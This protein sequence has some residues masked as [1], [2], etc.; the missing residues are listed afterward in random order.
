MEEKGKKKLNDRR[1]AQLLKQIDKGNVV[2]V[3]GQELLSVEIDGEKIMLKD[4]ILREIANRL[5]LEFKEGMDFAQFSFEAQ[6]TAWS[7]IDSDPYYETDK[8]ISELKA[9]DVAIPEPLYKLLSID[10]F[11]KVIT[12]T[13]NDFVYEAMKKQRSGPVKQLEYKKNSTEEDIS[14]NEKDFVYHM[15][16]KVSPIRDYV[17]TDDDMLEFMHC[18]MDEKR[19]PT[20]LASMLFSKYLLVIGCNYPYWLFRFFFHSMKYSQ[21]TGSSNTLG[22]LAD[23]KL[24]SKLV[25]FLSRV[26]AGIHED[27]VNFVNELYVKWNKY[28]AKEITKKQIFIS[29]ANEDY[30]T[31]SRIASCFDKNKYKVWFDKEVLKVGDEFDK[32]IQRTI[33]ECDA[34]IP[35]LS[36]A[37]AERKGYFRREWKWGDNVA[38]DWYPTKFVYPIRIE[39]IDIKSPIFENFRE[40][41]IEEYDASNPIKCVNNVCQQIEL[42]VLKK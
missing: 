39:E 33:G 27:A 6:K 11:D 29:Y 15:F 35:I 26:N 2:L 21:T 30:N 31:A 17:L 25:D 18:W 23:S 38:G 28:K 36:K 40:L 22:M 4:Y 41:H 5:E 1:W 37:T 3:I 10:K 32:I 16:G 8:I 12:T 13:F 34:F 20:N 14:S 24:D 42:Q 7:R 9:K 19:R